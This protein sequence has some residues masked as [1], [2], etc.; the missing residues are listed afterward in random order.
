MNETE[1]QKLNEELLQ[2][3][4]KNLPELEKLL[5]S[6]LEDHTYGDLVYRF[7]HG[8]FKVYWIQGITEQIV[9]ILKDL[10]PEGCTINKDFEEILKEGTGKVFSSNHNKEWTKHTRPMIEAFFH[11]KYFLEMAVKYGKELERAPYSL[12][13]GWAGF[14][15]L[16]NLR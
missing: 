15:Y 13:S 1:I 10:A 7:Y 16:F 14:L 2:N 11:A 9:N 3:I 5:N 6:I 12:P 4:K 8:S